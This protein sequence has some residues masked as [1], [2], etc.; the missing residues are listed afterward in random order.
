MYKILFIDEEKVSFE[1]FEDFVERTTVKDDIEVYTQ[2]PLGDLNEMIEHIIEINPDAIISDYLLNDKRDD[3]DYNV[4]YNGVELVERFLEIRESFPCFVLTSF[5]A[6][7]MGE[8]KDVNKIYIKHILHN[9]E[10]LK[11]DATFLDRIIF[12][13]RHYK[14]K[15]GNA[16]KELIGLI[17]LRT[18]GKATLEQETRIIELDSLIEKSIN[19]EGSIPVEFKSL[20]N[21]DKL[22]DILSK[23]DELIKKVE[24]G[25]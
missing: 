2:L 19:K 16:E 8:S 25:K 20:S 24:D 12:Q 7:A 4:P 3:I 23:V 5:D 1:H 13:I 6:L 11:A 22:S 15:I 14:T 17:D 18:L 9:T 21:T 10:K